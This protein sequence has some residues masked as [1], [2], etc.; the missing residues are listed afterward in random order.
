MS[1]SPTQSE[2]QQAPEPRRRRADWRNALYTVIFHSNTPAGKAFDVALL[3]AIVGSVAAV[4]LESVPEIDAM[5]HCE[6]RKIEWVFTIGFTIEYIL[7]LVSARNWKS[8]AF[9]FFG[10]VDFLSTTPTYLQYLLPGGQYLLIIRVLRLLRMFRILKMGRHLREADLF[11]SAL[12]AGR[13]KIMVFLFTITALVMVMGTIMYLIEGPEHGFTSIPESVYWAV[14]T[15]TTVGYGDISP[16]TWLGQFV[17]SIA[18]ITGWAVLAVP[19]GII[20]VEVA[21]RSNFG[22]AQVPHDHPGFTGKGALTADAP[23]CDRC[24][25]NGVQIDHRFCARCGE[26]LPDHKDPPTETADD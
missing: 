14:V 26:R 25:F 21:R 1:E 22:R 19:T 13:P 12:K 11:M 6:L 18:M 7:R 16:Q 10:I 8:Y 17:A 15:M 24:G 20:G 3:F 4:M 23:D 9:S 5:F 2:N